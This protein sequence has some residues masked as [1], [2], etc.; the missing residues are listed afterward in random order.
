MKK[1]IRLILNPCSLINTSRIV[2]K[3]QTTELATIRF[4]LKTSAKLDVV[5][6]LVV[7]I[8]SWFYRYPNV[9]IVNNKMQKLKDSFQRTLRL[10]LGFPFNQG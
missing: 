5:R 6:R 4:F 9:K 7:S 2:A 3:D 1:V 8:F 10:L